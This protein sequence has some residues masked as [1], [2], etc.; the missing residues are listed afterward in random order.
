MLGFLSSIKNAVWFMG[1]VILFLFIGTLVIPNNMQTYT[2]ILDTLLVTWIDKVNLGVSWW[3]VGIILS[4]GLVGLSTVICS[5]NSLRTLHISRRL[6]LKNVSPHICHMGILIML[7]GHV[8]GAVTGIRAEGTVAEGD[9]FTISDEISYSV[10]TITIESSPDEG[11]FW[12][13]RGTWID[14][15]IAVKQGT[16]LPARPAFIKVS[17][18]SYTVPNLKRA[19]LISWDAGIGAYFFYLQEGLY[20]CRGALST[21]EAR[22]D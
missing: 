7:T 12:Q 11:V 1:L 14:N 9:V 8:I 6:S 16:I 19:R 21:C 3:V 22:E 20:F 17:G 5:I 13:I 4:L 10:E 2:D 15:G 18:Y